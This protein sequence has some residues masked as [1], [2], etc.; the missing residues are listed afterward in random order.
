METGF[1]HGNSDAMKFLL[2]AGSVP[3]QFLRWGE[4]NQVVTRLIAHS[5]SDRLA[6]IVGVGNHQTT[7]LGG[8]KLATPAG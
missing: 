1:A 4:T 2:G 5:S 8:K 7:G 3:K 6:D